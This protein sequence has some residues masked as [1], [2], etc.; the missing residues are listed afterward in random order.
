MVDDLT[1]KVAEAMW[2]ADAM[3]ARGKDRSIPW[4]ESD[5]R[6]QARWKSLANAA[7]DACMEE[8]AK[9]AREAALYSG[10]PA[11]FIADEIADAIRALSQGE[12][13]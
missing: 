5:P 13:G 10:C 6:D 11:D 1:E 4:C 7:I 12:R 3:R 2:R 9:V 8:A